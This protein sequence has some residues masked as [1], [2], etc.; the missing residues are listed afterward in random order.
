VPIWKH[1]AVAHVIADMA[2]TTFAM[3]SIWML[4]SQMADRGGYDIRLEAAAAKEWN[5]VRAWEI[6]DKTL[7]MRGGRGYETESSLKGRGEHPIP[8]E[9]MMRDSR[10][11]LIFE[12]SSEIMHL[13]MARE[14]VDKHLEVAGAMIDPKNGMREKAGALPKILG[15][16]AQWYPK[17]FLK[18][19]NGSP[20]DD[21]WGPLAPHLRA[22]ER[23][24]RKLARESFHGMAVYQAKME[25]KQGFLFRAVDIVMELF[26]MSATICR[27][28]RMVDDRHPEAAQGLELAD[29]FC[30]SSRRKVNRLFRELWRNDDAI[31]NTVAAGV[32][33]GKQAWL[34]GGVLDLGLTDEAFQTRSL[35]EL[36]SKLAEAESA[37]AAG[38]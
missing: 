5:T 31:K 12:G 17:L 30:R 38:A 9:R 2:A 21:G 7:Q 11:N 35:V 27:A 4:A 24:S 26:A 25:R 15:F 32:M 23:A 3:D 18:G 6:V 20:Q 37:R 13:F 33:S 29:L 36:R 19:R 10:I 16:Y 1:E 34:E 8:V 28:R 22:V 14:A